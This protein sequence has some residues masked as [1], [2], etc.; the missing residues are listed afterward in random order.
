MLNDVQG[1]YIFS[2]KK[3]GMRNISVMDVD[4]TNKKCLAGFYESA[5]H[6]RV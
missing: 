4:I 5:W 1:A 6:F 3:S 2:G